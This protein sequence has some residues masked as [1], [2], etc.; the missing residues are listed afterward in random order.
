M[1]VII[2]GDR[3]RFLGFLFFFFRKEIDNYGENS[4][5][6]GA[7]NLRGRGIGPKKGKG[8]AFK[9]FLNVAR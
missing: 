2:R 8:I 3:I 4:G 1:E 6:N 5:D 7:R 9:G